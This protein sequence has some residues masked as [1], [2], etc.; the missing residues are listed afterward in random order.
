MNKNMGGGAVVL[1]ARDNVATATRDLEAGSRVRLGGM[2]K[3]RIVVLK[4][5]IRFGHK[6]SLKPISKDTAIIKYGEIIGLARCHIPEGS[7]VHVHNVESQRTGQGKAI[8]EISR[9]EGGNKA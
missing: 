7:H 9:Y 3:R 1:S 4:E 8:T 5:P 6:F 2:E